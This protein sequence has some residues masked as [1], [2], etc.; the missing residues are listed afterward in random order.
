MCGKLCIHDSGARPSPPTTARRWSSPDQLST[1]SPLPLPYLISLYLV[2]FTLVYGCCL[3]CTRVYLFLPGAAPI[4]RFSSLLATELH[5]TAPL[6]LTVR[7]RLLPRLTQS[8]AF[9]VQLRPRNGNERHLLASY[10]IV[11]L[12]RLLYFIDLCF[13]RVASVWSCWM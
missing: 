10:H 13:T 2:P 6:R 9:Q 5:E 3:F 1:T 11:D 8:V 7:P 12:L 4:R